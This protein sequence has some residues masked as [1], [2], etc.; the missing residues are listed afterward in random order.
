VFAGTFGKDNLINFENAD[1]R[2]ENP[3][4]REEPESNTILIILTF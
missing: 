2:E 4:F 3:D 1:S